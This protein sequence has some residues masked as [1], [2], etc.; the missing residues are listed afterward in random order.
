MRGDSR[1]LINVVLVLEQEQAVKHCFSMYGECQSSVGLKLLIS[2]QWCWGISVPLLMYLLFNSLLYIF[3]TVFTHSL[4]HTVF[5]TRSFPHGLLHTVSKYIHDLLYT[6]VYTWPLHR[7]Y[8][9]WILYR[10][11]LQCVQLL[12]VVN[13]FAYQSYL[14]F[15]LYFHLEGVTKSSIFFNVCDK[16]NQLQILSHFI[17]CCIFDTTSR[18][19]PNHNKW[20]WM[21]F[22]EEY[23]KLLFYR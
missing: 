22:K 7:I 20:K 6:G 1:N 5:Y 9:T 12:C 2:E 23:F 16:V 4:L 10:K 11:T 15:H 21:S 14:Y 19:H 3:H 13:H 17:G 18:T 8:C